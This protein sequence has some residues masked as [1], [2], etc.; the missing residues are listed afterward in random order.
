M[1][2]I[3]RKWMSNDVPDGIA[4]TSRHNSSVAFPLSS[5]IIAWGVSPLPSVSHEVLVQF[6]SRITS[7]A[8]CSRYWWLGLR[9][10]TF[11]PSVIIFSASLSW[12][13]WI[14][15][16]RFLSPWRIL[17]RAVSSTCYSI[18]LYN[19]FCNNQLLQL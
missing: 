15:P 12:R 7:T 11:V 8:L 13:K 1:A 19:R 2:S 17:N 6:P 9:W 3:T 18:K 4:V 14:W 10:W 5:V 16:E